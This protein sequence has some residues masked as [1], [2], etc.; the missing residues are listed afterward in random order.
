MGGSGLVPHTGVLSNL[1]SAA[2]QQASILAGSLLLHVGCRLEF[3]TPL[4]PET[5]V[6]PAVYVPSGFVFAVADNDGRQAAALLGHSWMGPGIG[7]LDLAVMPPL[8]SV[9]TPA[10]LEDLLRRA[11]PHN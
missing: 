1:E 4:G 8:G 3:K 2:P 7:D 6:R 5:E 10:E 9:L 11:D